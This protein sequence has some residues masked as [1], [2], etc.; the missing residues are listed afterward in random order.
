MTDAEK[1]ETQSEAP[2]AVETSGPDAVSGAGETVNQDAWQPDAWQPDAWVPDAAHTPVRAARWKLIA[3]VTLPRS[4][5]WA[6]TF[7]VLGL[8]MSL[9]VG[10]GFPVGIAGVVL[11]ILVLRQPGERRGMAVWALCLSLL[12]LLYSAGWLWWAAATQ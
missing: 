9:V 3:P 8:V 7:A 11:A 5:S 12:S 6:L 4:A 10:W 1:A 2:D